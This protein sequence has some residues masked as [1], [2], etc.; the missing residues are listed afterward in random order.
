MQEPTPKGIKPPTQPKPLASL[1][2]MSNRV[3]QGGSL[4]P[5]EEVHMLGKLLGSKVNTNDA[6]P[7]LI[8]L[9]KGFLKRHPEMAEKLAEAAAHYQSTDPEPKKEE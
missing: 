1:E 2:E 7:S 6:D 3:N 8:A 9:G 5:D 4:T